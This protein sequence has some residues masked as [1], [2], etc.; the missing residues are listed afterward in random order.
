MK[1][2]NRQ[3]VTEKFNLDYQEY[4][5]IALLSDCVLAYSPSKKEWVSWRVSQGGFHNGHRTA[6]GNSALHSF[7]DRVGQT[8]HRVSNTIQKTMANLPRRRAWIA[9]GWTSEQQRAMLRAMPGVV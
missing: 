8:L 9:D 7:A 3:T 6:D 2:E 5:L 1:A 4:Y